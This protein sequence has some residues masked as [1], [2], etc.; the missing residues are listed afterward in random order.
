MC[1]MNV[2]YFIVNLVDHQ[3]KATKKI[4]P[5]IIP[6]IKIPWD[7][8]YVNPNIPSKL[9]G[10]DGSDNAIHADKMHI[11]SMYREVVW[12]TVDVVFSFSSSV[13]LFCNILFPK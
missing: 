4:P 8:L 6:E 13:Q 2:K 3:V 10:V 7:R 5:I 11:M 1:F 9:D 12:A